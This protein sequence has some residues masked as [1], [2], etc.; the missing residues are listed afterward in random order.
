M[1]KFL[2]FL[3]YNSLYLNGSD[4]PNWYFKIDTNKICGLGS[5]NQERIA[6]IMAK[7][8]YIKQLEI[9]VSIITKLSKNDSKKDLEIN[10]VQ[11][12]ER[13][14]NELVIENNEKINDIFYIKIC[15]KKD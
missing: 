7:S 14:I 1:K 5:S 13:L 4:I 8:D 3:I 2:L 6:L 11:T 12:S 10:S 15:R 9:K